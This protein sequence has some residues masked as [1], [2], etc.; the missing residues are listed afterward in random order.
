MGEEIKETKITSRIYST[1]SLDR[2]L[3]KLQRIE[4]LLGKSNQKVNSLKKDIAKADEAFK[5]CL[6]EEEFK[7]LL[8]KFESKEEISNE[9]K[10]ELIILQFD[11]VFRRFLAMHHFEYK[12]RIYEKGNIIPELIVREMQQNG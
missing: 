4:D 10:P 1:Y 5:Q 2:I 9:Q 12:G 7:V 3:G 6:T 8:K 11:P